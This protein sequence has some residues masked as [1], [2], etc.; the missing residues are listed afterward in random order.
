MGAGGAFREC[1]TKFG[2]RGGMPEEDDES[3]D[4]AISLTTL[5]QQG[6]NGRAIVE[7]MVAVL[8][9]GLILFLLGLRGVQYENNWIL[10][11]ILPVCLWLL[12]S[13]RITGFK[14]FGVELKTAIQ[15]ASRQTISTTR[16]YGALSSLEYDA[17][18]AGEKG[19][20]NRIA[21]HNEQ[22]LAALSFVLE[23]QNYYKPQVIKRYL[24]EMLE[25]GYLKWIV[26]NDKEGKLEGLIRADALRNYATL[27]WAGPADDGYRV[28]QQSI[29]TGAID[30]MPGVVRSSFAVKA[31][32]TKGTAIQK[33][34]KIDAEYLP[35]VD[36][37]GRFKGVVSRGKLLSEVMSALIVAAQS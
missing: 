21:Q 35:V 9:V 15:A 32:D 31:S 4:S 5:P 22:K 7:T 10:I 2:G 8:I 1:G 3:S 20:V 33:F 18:D 28:I 17:Q 24:D 16:A 23:R 36:E 6:S 19:S 13:G 34:S 30:K 14:A 27:P 29:E 25:N 26:F 37:L 11:A 12:F